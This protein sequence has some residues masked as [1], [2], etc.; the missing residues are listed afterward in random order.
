M[1]VSQPHNPI[2]GLIMF[3]RELEEKIDLLE[4]YFNNKRSQGIIE[5][6]G[7]NVLEAFDV[8]LDELLKKGLNNG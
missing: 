6:N 1:P 5:L 8:I 4:R 3:K 2:W 7:E